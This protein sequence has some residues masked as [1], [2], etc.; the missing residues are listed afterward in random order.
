MAP[1]PLKLFHVFRFL[2]AGEAKE[3][4]AETR[5]DDKSNGEDIVL[6]E[7]WVKLHVVELQGND[8]VDVCVSGVGG[9]GR[10]AE[11]DDSNWRN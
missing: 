10:D 3:D 6:V 4:E 1:N 8:Q 11:L 2:V 9:E 7:G 5:P